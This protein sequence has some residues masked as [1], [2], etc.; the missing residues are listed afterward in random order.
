MK[1]ETATALWANC[2][3]IEIYK[4]YGYRG[5]YGDT[6]TGIVVEDFNIIFETLAYM[7]LEEEPGTLVDVLQDLAKCRTD[8][9]GKYKI[10]VY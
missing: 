8:S 9:I 5:G 2:N 7:I 1:L 10:I 3:E 4:D 6:T